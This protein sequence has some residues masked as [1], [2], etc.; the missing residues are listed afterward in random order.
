MPL[1]VKWFKIVYRNVV[2]PFCFICCDNFDWIIFYDYL[3]YDKK[4]VAYI[5]VYTF[6][7]HGLRLMTGQEFVL[8]DKRH[9]T[10]DWF[11]VS[12]CLLHDI[13]LCSY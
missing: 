4:V 9:K 13:T 10:A 2:C 12:C 7:I 6:L 5:S 8:F 3:L 1:S 11:N